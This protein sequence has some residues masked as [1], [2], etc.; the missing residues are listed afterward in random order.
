VTIRIEIIGDKGSGKTTVFGVVHKALKDA[1]FGDIE[2]EDGES[3]IGDVPLDRLAA[4]ARHTRISLASVL[5]LHGA[6]KRK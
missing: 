1:G 2:V 6:R 4:M 5:T 3:T